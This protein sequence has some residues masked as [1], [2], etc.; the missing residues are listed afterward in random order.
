MKNFFVFV[1]EQ[2][3]MPE[4]MTTLCGLIMTA[5]YSEGARVAYTIIIVPER[6]AADHAKDARY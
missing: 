6:K 2:L 4:T 5:Y 3:E 1:H